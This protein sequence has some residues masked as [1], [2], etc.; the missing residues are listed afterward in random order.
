ME[1]IIIRYDRLHVLIFF[2]LDVYIESLCHT[3]TDK[4]PMICEW[5]PVSPV[6]PSPPNAV[7]EGADDDP[8]VQSKAL[9]KC[10]A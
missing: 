3:H 2:S 5:F 6:N 8:G 9:L 1:G 4:S 7:D 10:E